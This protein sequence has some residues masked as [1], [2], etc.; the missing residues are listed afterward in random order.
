MRSLVADYLYYIHDK[1]HSLFLSSALNE[2][3]DNGTLP[4][5]ITFGIA[6]LSA[7]Y[8][9]FLFHS[10]LRLTVSRFSKDESLRARI[11]E[12]ALIARESLKENMEIVSLENI[13]A[14]ILVGEHA[15]GVS[16]RSAEIMYDSWAVRMAQVLRL[17][18]D[19][20]AKST[21]ENEIRW[22]VWY[23][24]CMIDTWSSIGHNVPK[25]IDAHTAR[26]E[27]LTPEDHL[28][29]CTNT[30]VLNPGCGV[31]LWTF[32]ARLALIYARVPDLHRQ[33]AAFDCN[34]Y[35][36]HESTA[37]VVA[38]LEKYYTEIPT[39]LQFNPENLQSHISRGIGH[40]FIALHLGFHHYSNLVHF[41]YL[42]P[43]R[44]RLFPTDMHA[45]RC[46]YHAGALSDILS[47]SLSQPGCETLYQTVGHMATVSSC[48]LLYILLLG[49]NHEIDA[50]KARLGTN[51]TKLI[52]LT[53]YWPAMHQVVS[54]TA[55]MRC[56]FIDISGQKDR[57]LEF[58][59]ACLISKSQTVHKLDNWMVRFLLYYALPLPPK[60]PD[61]FS[62]TFIERM[63]VTDDVFQKFDL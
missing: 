11:F 35:N 63:D 49:E 51:F 58:Q 34:E 61:Q 7:G 50:A 3:I 40:V 23:S 32:M 13:K 14:C 52:E 26:I 5:S 48:V 37:E 30:R 44:S 25:V 59:Y 31:G 19:D 36:I 54:I 1:P 28:Q 10:L 4:R 17:W 2:A 39:S 18:E 46:K 27:N 42:D 56:T 9:S 21:I 55:Q 33:L 6:A 24:C 20:P 22:R 45:E 47:T 15:A 41:P 53:K 62:G 60:L 43:R 38:E 8:V 29:R 16:D 57:L 12:F